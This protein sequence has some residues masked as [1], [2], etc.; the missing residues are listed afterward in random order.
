MEYTPDI[1][2]TVPSLSC[3]SPQDKSTTTVLHIFLHKIF[4]KK[5]EDLKMNR[6]PLTPTYVNLMT[7]P[8]RS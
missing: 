6:E 4:T 8:P 3:F 1:C 5:A 2:F 7:F